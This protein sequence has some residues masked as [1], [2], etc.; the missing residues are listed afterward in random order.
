MWQSDADSNFDKRCRDVNNIFEVNRASK[1]KCEEQMH[2][3]FYHIVRRIGE[4]GV[5][6][7]CGKGSDFNM[8]PFIFSFE[9]K[10]KFNSG[11]NTSQFQ[12]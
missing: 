9:R 3:Y 7:Q 6:W 2:A 10:K 1:G 4:S 12:H 5:Y 11:E 8:Y